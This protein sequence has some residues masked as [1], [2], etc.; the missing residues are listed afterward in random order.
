MDL[1]IDILGTLFRALLTGVII[2]GGF[3]L[4]FIYV[5]Y[6]IRDKI[7]FKHKGD[8]IWWDENPYDLNAP[9]KTF[10]NMPIPFKIAFFIWL[11][12]TAN[13][14]YYE[15]TNADFFAQYFG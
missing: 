7:G 4:V 12:V 11:L 6:W 15:F 2:W 3:T 10:K 9:K 8:D 14:I 5:Y 1:I 13:Q